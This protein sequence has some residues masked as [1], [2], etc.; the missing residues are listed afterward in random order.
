MEP[1]L[2]DQRI[3]PNPGSGNPFTTPNVG[4]DPVKR[5][6][7]VTLRASDVIRGGCLQE[8]HGES[9]A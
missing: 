8:A 1:S 4:T 3:A 2:A 7:H 9:R 6:Y 5:R